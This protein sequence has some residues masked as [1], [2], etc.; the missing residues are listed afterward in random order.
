MKTPE[1]AIIGH[2]NEGKSSVLSTLAEDDSVRISPVPG[3]TTECRTF[4]VVID[5]RELL[6]FTDTPGF[7]H[8]QQILEVL[9][10]FNGSSEARLQQLMD[11][12]A[13]SPQFADDHELLRPVFRGAGI[14]YVVDG[15]RP[16]RSVDRAEMEILRLIG[17]PR[18]AV[19]N[20]KDDYFEYLD[21][22]K[23]EFRKRFNANRLFNAHRATYIE[24][25]EL[26]ESLKAIDQDW[27]SILNE[28]ITS[29]KTDWETRTRTCS[30][31]ICSLLKRS[32]SLQLVENLSSGQDTTKKQTKLVQEYSRRVM[33]LEARA[34]QQ[35]RSLFKHNIFDY[36]L[37]QHSILRED[38]FNEKTW[39]L[40]GLTRKQFLILGGLGGAAIGAG[41]D[42]AALGHGLGL[43]T[44]LGGIAGTVGAIAGKNHLSTDASFM[45]VK[46][47]GPQVLVG[48]AEN[49]SLLFV[50][51]NR[52]LLYYQQSINWAHGRRDYPESLTDGHPHETAGFTKDW[53]A[54]KLRVCHR[55]FKSLHQA[56][57]GDNFAQEKE[58]QDILFTTLMEISNDR[59][60]HQ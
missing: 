30:E 6:S 13:S 36:R 3:E 9:E 22:W 28:I 35:I 32:L 51:L 29:F 53:S 60:S 39:H 45:G 5:G 16:V 52:A 40:L 48:P 31:I 25:I 56:G 1:I 24:R 55:F 50:L 44:A 37:S 7:Q 41:I 58:L 11:F 2:P 14:I 17:R 46:I 33:D 43:F 38:L 12:T 10:T 26:L 15:S 18:M 19:I 27:H 54:G 4:P 42:I 57:S 59:R 34:H 8:P 47:A 20:C 21:E 49:I 23:D